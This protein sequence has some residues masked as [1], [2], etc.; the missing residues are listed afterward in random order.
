VFVRNN[1]DICVT[2]TNQVGRGGDALWRHEDAVPAL[3]TFRGKDFRFRSASVGTIAHSNGGLGGGRAP[4]SRTQSAESDGGNGPAAACNGGNGRGGEAAVM[5][6]NG[7][8]D[9]PKRLFVAHNR[10]HGGVFG[11]RN[12]SSTDVSAAVGDAKRPPLPPATARE[13]LAGLNFAVSL[14]RTPSGR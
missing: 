13:R 7:E 11:L 5:A 4:V 6:A 8:A 3:T 9:T 12:R 14:Y 2:T 1:S 10:G